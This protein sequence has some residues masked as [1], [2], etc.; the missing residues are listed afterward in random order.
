MRIAGGAVVAAA[1]L[2][3]LTGC[4][5]K[6]APTDY[7]P[8]VT[9]APTAT[10]TVTTS[11]TATPSSTPESDPGPSSTPSATRAAGDPNRPSG[12]C[13]DSALGVTIIVDGDGG[14]AGS[15]D[16]Q[17]LFANTGGTS[18]V[19]RG[20]PGVSVV[21]GDGGDQLGVPADRAQAGAKTVR[22]GSG[23]TAVAPLRITNIRPDGGPLP[24]CTVKSGRGYRVYPP[25]STRAFYVEQS[26][27]AACAGS[28][29]VFMT[30]G[31]V[32]A[33]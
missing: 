4:G 3:V 19:L 20:A 12:Q 27:A 7:T 6:A 21:T 33:Q 11:P 17:V 18:C 5:S 2:L 32:T 9:V 10:A 26:G 29:P 31:S 14:G 8:T 16:Y 28:G 22:L 30:V 13:A 1:A 24:D 25:H 15:S 23:E